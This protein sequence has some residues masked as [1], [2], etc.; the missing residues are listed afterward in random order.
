MNFIEEFFVQDLN[1]CTELIKF[2]SKQKS[3]ATPGVW[4]SENYKQNINPDVKDSLDLTIKGSLAQEP[5]IKKYLGELTAIAQ[6]YIEKYPSCNYY[7]KWGIKEP[8][9]IQFYQPGGGFK[10]FHT[11]RGSCQTPQCHRHLVFMT[12][13]NT[14]TDGGETEFLNQQIKVKPVKGKTLIWPAD[15]THTHRGIPSFTQKKYIV[16][17]WFSFI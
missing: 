8:F 3:K 14:V 10:V 5:C 15:W 1:L 12:Y 2:F 11:E 17:G 13:L 9:N 7:Q 16:T 6:Q 4:F